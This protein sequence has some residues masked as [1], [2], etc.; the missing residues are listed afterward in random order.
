MKGLSTVSILALVV[1][2]TGSV[3]ADT[4]LKVGPQQALAEALANR[5]LAVSLWN[6]TRQACQARD[7]SKMFKVMHAVAEQMNAQPTD[8]MKYS[9]R[10][11]YSGCKQMLLDVS[12]INGACLNKTPTKHEI[13]NYKRPWDESSKQC[14]SEIAKPNLS[15]AEP[16]K[17]YTDEELE[18]IQR[19]EGDT[20][21]E[22]AVMKKARGQ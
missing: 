12:S 1:G 8:D 9:A 18:S 17:Q 4:G 20:E 15:L 3:H 11:V 2:M 7:I 16:P 22:I 10:F 6:D 19:S 13:E 5:K 21:E 14:D